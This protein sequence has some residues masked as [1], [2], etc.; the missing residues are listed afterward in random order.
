[1]VRLWVAGLFWWKKFLGFRGFHSVHHFFKRFP[2]C[3]R[4]TNGFFERHEPMKKMRS[5]APGFL[6]HNNLNGLLLYKADRFEFLP[7]AL[8][9][10][11]PVERLKLCY[12]DSWIWNL[13][14]WGSWFLDEIHDSFSYSLFPGSRFAC[15]CL[16]RFFIFSLVFQSPPCRCCIFGMT[17]KPPCQSFIHLD[18]AERKDTVPRQGCGHGLVDRKHSN[19]LVWLVCSSWKSGGMYLHQVQGSAKFN[20]YK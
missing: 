8:T 1:M 13:E 15:L 5:K 18:P 19:Y 2:E 4:G 10:G 16:H 14:E 20:S 6:E 3:A 7:V 11:I 12:I 17:S 9:P